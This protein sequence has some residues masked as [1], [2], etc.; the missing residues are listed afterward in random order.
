M[1]S[2][3]HAL[4]KQNALEHANRVL[5]SLG[6]HIATQVKSARRAH[7]REQTKLVSERTKRWTLLLLLLQTERWTTSTPR[8]RGERRTERRRDVRSAGALENELHATC[9]RETDE[10]KRGRCVV[11]WCVSTRVL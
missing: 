3:E 2:S 1:K 5:P 6:F 8:E 7:A 9:E 10:E 11:V 4:A